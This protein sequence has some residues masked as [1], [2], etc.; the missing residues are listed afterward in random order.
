MK[1]W[2]MRNGQG[3]VD[4]E[5][6]LSAS[7]MAVRGRIYRQRR[8]ERQAAQVAAAAHVAA[9]VSVPMRMWS[10]QYGPG[11]ILMYLTSGTRRW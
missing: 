7:Y 9:A 4:A 3:Q 6:G 1:A 10:N 5:T 8:K 11:P 2:R